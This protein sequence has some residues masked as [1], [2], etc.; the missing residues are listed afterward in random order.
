VPATIFCE[1]CLGKTDEWI[2]VGTI[3]T[4]HT[5]TLLH[6][7]FDGSH[8]ATPEIIAFIAFADGGIIHRLGAVVPEEITIGMQV[9]VVFKPKNDRVG[10]ILDIVYF[11]PT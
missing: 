3:G 1:R 4:V 2:D 10:S 9:E 8:R 7:R 11:K 6:E 5:F